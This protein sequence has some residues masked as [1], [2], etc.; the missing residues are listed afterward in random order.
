MRLLM[1]GNPNVGKS[2]LFNRLTGAR[3]LASNYPGTTVELVR[4]VL[5]VHGRKIEMVDL[6][7]VYSLDSNCKVE[8]IVMESLRNMGPDDIVLNV[9][10]STNLER[11]LGLTLE[12]T[13]LQKPMLLALNFSDEAV[14]TG[15][16]IDISALENRLGVPCVP[17]VGTTGEGT[18]SLVEKIPRAGGKA[19]SFKPSAKWAEVGRILTEVQKRRPRRHTLREHLSDATLQPFPGAFLAFLVLAVSFV[20]VRF[21]GEGLIERVMNPLFSAYWT[22]LML[23]TSEALRG[24]PWFHDMLIGS[25]VAVEIDYGES[26]GL[27]TTG[28]YVVFAVVFPYVVAFYLVLSV[29][30]DCGYLPRLAVLADRLMHPLGL[31]GMGVIP[32]LLGLGCKVPGVLATRIMESKRERFICSTVTIVA[33]PC[34]AQTAVIVGLAGRW[35]ASALAIVFFTLLLVGYLLG[36]LLNRYYPG[37]SPEL[38]ADIPPYRMPH[39]GTLLKKIGIRLKGFLLEAI[40]FVLLGVLFANML[41]SWGVIHFIGRVLAPLMTEVLGLPHDAAGALLLGFLRKDIAVGMLAPMALDFTQTIVACVVLTLYFPCIATFTVMLK[42]LGV[43][44]TVAA[45]LLMVG[46]ALFVGAG[47]F[48]SLR[49]FRP[50]MGF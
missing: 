16:H 49:Y 24:A 14:H 17:I 37:E 41:Y 38:L 39:F 11:N 28:L 23:E 34:M 19:F 21:I 30:E 33:A 15:V 5:E 6:P 3:V 32:L 48:Q 25:G 50:W 42:E 22:P 40:P 46:T 20:V 47:L 10:D 31:H 36:R 13:R 4:G 45:A 44:R 1:I 29:L 7:G 12:L 43:L 2:T 35:G 18:R 27:L 9:V 8:E 26:F